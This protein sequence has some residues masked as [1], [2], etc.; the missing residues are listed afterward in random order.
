ML[1]IY[2][3]KMFFFFTSHAVDEFSLSLCCYMPAYL[4]QNYFDLVNLSEILNTGLHFFTEKAGLVG[5]NQ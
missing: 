2:L 5:V 1:F 3:H 4:K